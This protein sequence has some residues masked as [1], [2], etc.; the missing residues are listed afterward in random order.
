M[1]V[2]LLVKKAISKFYSSILERKEHHVI[3]MV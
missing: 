1:Y 2:F 3:S